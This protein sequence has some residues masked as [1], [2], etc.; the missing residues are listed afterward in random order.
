MRSAL[1]LIALSIF[2]F[3]SSKISNDF[4]SLLAAIFIVFFVMDIISLYFNIPDK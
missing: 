1:C 3:N 4:L 2:H